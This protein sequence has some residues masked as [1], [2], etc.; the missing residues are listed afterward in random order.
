MLICYALGDRSEERFQRFYLA[1]ALE[2]LVKNDLVY[3]LS[4]PG[5]PRLDAAGVH[6]R[7][8]PAGKPQLWKDIP[9]IL[10]FGGGDCKDLAAWEIAERMTRGEEARARWIWG[11]DS[12]G[13]AR[14]H[15]QVFKKGGAISDPSRRLGMTGDM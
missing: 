8:D 4:H 3:L 11:H 5:T 9:T 6:Y 2:H 14:F 15:I 10:R 12:T 1:Y 13:K 7:R